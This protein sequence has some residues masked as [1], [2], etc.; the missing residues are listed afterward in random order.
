MTNYV[1]DKTALDGFGNFFEGAF[2][3]Y[4]IV[5]Y[6]VFWHY[7]VTGSQ[8]DTWRNFCFAI[9]LQFHHRI[10]VSHVVLV[11]FTDAPELLIQCWRSL[12][13]ASPASASSLK[14][15]PFHICFY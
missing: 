11:S 14:S 3:A 15:L 9:T 12:Y 1:F 8:A 13:Q 10:V 6:K 2:K 4:F 5:L 7:S